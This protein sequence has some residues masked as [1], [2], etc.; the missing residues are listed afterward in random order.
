MAGYRSTICELFMTQVEVSLDP[1]IV[2]LSYLCDITALALIPVSSFLVTQHTEA[3]H[4]LS[5]MMM[6]M[7]VVTQ[8]WVVCV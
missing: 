3:R 1:V 8:R 6:M 5:E 7:I 2:G 4:L